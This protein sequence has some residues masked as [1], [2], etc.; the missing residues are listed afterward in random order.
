MSVKRASALVAVGLVGYALLALLFP[1]SSTAAQWQLH[2]GNHESIARARAVAAEHGIDVT[3]WPGESGFRADR[4]LERALDADGHGDGGRAGEIRI[5]FR[6]PRD[7]EHLVGVRLDSTGRPTALVVQRGPRPGDDVTVTAATPVA[8]RAFRAFVPGAGSYHAVAQEDLGEPGVRFRWERS[9]ANPAIVDKASVTVSGS[10]VRDLRYGPAVTEKSGQ[11]QPVINTLDTVSNISVIVAGLFG[12]VLYIIAKGRGL[13]PRGL[14]LTLFGGSWLLLVVEV[15]ADLDPKLQAL[16]TP[17]NNS[18]RWT[19][20]LGTALFALPVGLAIAG[21][22]PSARRRFYAQLLAFEALLVRG[23]VG[24]QP[25]G[26]AILAGMAAGGWLAAIPH[27]LRATGFFGAYRISDASPDVVMRSG[28][29]PV[30]I[31][32][33]TVPALLAFGLVVSFVDDKLR[34]RLGRVLG[35]LLAFVILLDDAVEPLGAALLGAALVTLLLDQLYRR[36][37]L[38]ALLAAAASGAWAMAAASRLVQPA[39]SIR[40]DGWTAALAGV[41]VAVAALVVAR[42]GSAKP[43]VPWEPRPARAERERIQAELQVARLAQERML[44]AAA[45]E[46]PGAEIASFCRPALHVGGDLF[47]FVTMSDGSVGIT[48]ADVSGKGIPAALVMTITKGLLL[49]ASDGRSDPLQ[50]LA[51]VNAGIHS[52]G[53]RSVFVTMLLGVFHP[54]LRTFRFVRAGHTPLLWR[55]AS[56]EVSALAPKG[57]GVGMTSP[58]MFS[59]VCE[60]STITTTPGDFLLLYSD[61]VTEAMNE[62]SEEFG[63]AR[64]FATVRDS[65]TTA[66][67]AEEARAVI[68]D[69]VD[70]FCGNAPVHDDMTLVVVKC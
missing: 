28:L 38:L 65:L 35:F 62:R 49:A 7:G 21:G 3:G 70:R 40:H 48:V 66:M 11:G 14:A 50:T 31:F 1:R 68:V 53:N 23:R 18:A 30:E 60:T 22:Y 16:F 10:E 61:G 33:N 17:G 52:L 45:P 4:H 8:E 29:V 25:V 58:R 37:D 56:G 26:A 57:I 34:N 54:T 63:D 32:S 55:R 69:A 5:G 19:L 42:W 51:D 6:D 46:I 43:F 9:G 44:P 47:D 36:V 67:S 27:L 41:V 20:I 15:W 39:A 13:V 24:S 2:L 59:A 12:V 64:L